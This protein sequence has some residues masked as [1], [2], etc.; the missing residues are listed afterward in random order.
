MLLNRAAYVVHKIKF[1]RAFRVL[2][3]PFAR[4]IY[5]SLGA[6]VIFAGQIPA[7]E[8]IVPR[9]MRGI[10]LKREW[11][12]ALAIIFW[13]SGVQIGLYAQQAS[14]L[15]P[16]VLAVVNRS[17]LEVK[18]DDTPLVRLKKERFNAALNEAK[19]R[20]DLYDRGFTRLPELI[21]VGERLFGAEVDLYDKPE[22][23]AQVLQRHLDVYSEAETNLEKQVKE[24]LATQADLER[25]RY[26]KLSVEIDLFKVKDVHD[27]H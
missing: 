13:A 24:G 6:D 22:E 21:E 19:A 9:A 14:K 10:G 18:D 3:F 8:S 4:V 20:F 11:S 2:F 17:A 26:N 5:P 25:L 16:K 7:P 15:S 1:S 23:K 12:C 27:E